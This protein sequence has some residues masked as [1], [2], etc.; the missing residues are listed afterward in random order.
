[1]EPGPYCPEC[2]DPLAD[3]TIEINRRGSRVNRFNGYLC[4]KCRKI[5]SQ[6][7]VDEELIEKIAREVEHEP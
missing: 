5:W 4:A 3:V 7:R 6:T 2:R 1:M